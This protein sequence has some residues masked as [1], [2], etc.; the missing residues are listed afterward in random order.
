MTYPKHKYSDIRDKI[1]EGVQKA[2]DK[3]IIKTAQEDGELIFSENGK[4][5]IMK[6]KEL[7]NKK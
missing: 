4:I 3:L 6:A 2:I 5:K 1:I 7:L